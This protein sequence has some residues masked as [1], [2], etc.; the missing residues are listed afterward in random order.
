ML[1]E[2]RNSLG[3]VGH[4][5]KSNQECFKGDEG[6]RKHGTGCMVGYWENREQTNH[7]RSEKEERNGRENERGEIKK[8][9]VKR[10]GRNIPSRVSPRGERR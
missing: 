10:R 4:S 6:L 5:W 3:T 2:H 1:V 7:G 8:A 9:V